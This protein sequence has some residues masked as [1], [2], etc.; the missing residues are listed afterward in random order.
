M[1]KTFGGDL[2]MHMHQNVFDEQRSCFYVAYVVLEVNYNIQRQ[3]IRYK[4][5]VQIF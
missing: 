3:T 5:L 2:M 4:D 1:K